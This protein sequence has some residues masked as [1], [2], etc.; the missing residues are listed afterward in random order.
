MEAW[1]GSLGPSLL[2]IMS[3]SILAE[4][5]STKTA[6]YTIAMGRRDSHLVALLRA[7]LL[8]TTHADDSDEFV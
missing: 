8:S 6:Q 5:F 3:R 7:Q 2:T 1:S 4:S